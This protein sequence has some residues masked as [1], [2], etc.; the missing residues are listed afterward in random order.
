M[1]ALLVYPII[2]EQQAAGLRN[3]ESPTADEKLVEM[4]VSPGEGDLQEAVEIVEAGVAADEEAPP[5]HRADVQLPYVEL[6]DFGHSRSFS[7]HTR[8]RCSFPGDREKTLSKRSRPAPG[9][10]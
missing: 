7:H 4:V 10:E 6:I 8:H 9:L 3:A 2:G 1:S 5:A